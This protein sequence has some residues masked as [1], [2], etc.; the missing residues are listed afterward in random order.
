M[1]K[2]MSTVGKIVFV[3]SLALNLAV[4]G[5]FVGHRLWHAKGHHHGLKQY[6]LSVIPEGKRTEIDKILTDY[7]NKYP[8]RPKRFMANWKELDQLLRADTFDRAAFEKAMNQNIEGENQRFIDGGKVIADIA[9]RLT[10]E[11]RIK[12]LDELGRKWKKR[13]HFF[14]R[15][16]GKNCQR[17]DVEAAKQDDAEKLEDQKAATMKAEEETPTSTESPDAESEN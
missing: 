15:H 16:N 5:A 10:K 7:K 1:M 17:P 8:K 9:E 14:K 2:G 6:V 4:L 3:V 11:E 13:R 12:V